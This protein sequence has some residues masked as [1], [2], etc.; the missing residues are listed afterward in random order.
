M[1]KQSITITQLI[2]IP[3]IPMLLRIQTI[4][5]AHTTALEP[6]IMILH[7][8]ALAALDI[9]IAYTVNIRMGVTLEVM[10]EEDM[11]VGTEVGTEEDTEDTVEDMEE[12]MAEDTGTEDM[13]VDMIMV[14]M[15]MGTA[16]LKQL[17]SFLVQGLSNKI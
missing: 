10:E 1:G 14:H 2:I 7:M 4:I 3:H 15:A 16:V 17:D 13:K 8:V 11:E 6:D 12:V 9:V 5:I